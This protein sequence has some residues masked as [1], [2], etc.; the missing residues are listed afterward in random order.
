LAAEHI[1]SSVQL[2]VPPNKC[3]GALTTEEV[4]L[5]RDGISADYEEGSCN[6][7]V[8]C[9]VSTYSSWP[10]DTRVLIVYYDSSEGDS[11]L[12]PLN[13]NHPTEGGWLFHVVLMMG[14]NIVD[15]DF[16]DSS[17]Y[18]EFGDY[19]N[20]MFGGPEQL[21]NVRI[22]SLTPAAYLAD[23]DHYG[24]KAHWAYEIA[25]PK[26]QRFIDWACQLDNQFCHAGDSQIIITQQK[27]RTNDNTVVGWIYGKLKKI[28]VGKSVTLKY[29][30]KGGSDV[31][32]L[33]RETGR[34]TEIT[35][36]RL[37]LVRSNNTQVI[38]PMPLIAGN[39]VDEI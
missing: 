14:R 26:N 28:G 27:D 10:E 38:I 16:D 23:I 5:R 34:I 33:V 3:A 18:V 2:A 25:N 35:S 15:L 7:N 39:T 24:K 32:S 1:L 4:A 20:R 37:R 31:S 9:L 36:K 12:Y 21:S 29:Y 8:A 30:P 11:R 19:F 6:Q 17:P 13:S 22:L